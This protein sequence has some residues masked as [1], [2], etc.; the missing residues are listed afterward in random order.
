RWSASPDTT[1]RTWTS[2]TRLACGCRLRTGP[3]NSVPG[4]SARSRPATTSATGR[5]VAS[6]PAQHGEPAPRAQ[7]PQDVVV[8]A[9]AVL[10]LADEAR[11]HAR[12]AIDDDEAGGGLGFDHLGRGDR[13][14]AGIA[15]PPAGCRIGRPR[16]GGARPSPVGEHEILQVDLEAEPEWSKAAYRRRRDSHRAHRARLGEHSARGQP[17]RAAGRPHC[18]P[19][20]GLVSWRSRAL[21]E[22]FVGRRT[23]RT[24]PLIGPA[25]AAV[26]CPREGT[27]YQAGARD[28]QLSLHHRPP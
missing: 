19:A 28:R 18:R 2:R 10:Q 16:E 4:I 20:I 13:A 9:V 23:L 22:P 17:V 21:M 3:R 6:Q 8:T 5:P 12:V 26:L 15:P 11:D 25:L 1:S 14:H 24:A 7:P 27:P